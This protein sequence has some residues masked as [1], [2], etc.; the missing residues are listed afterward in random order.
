MEVFVTNDSEFA[1]RLLMNCLRKSGLLSE[2]RARNLSIIRRERRKF[3][4]RKSLKRLRRLE[5]KGGPREGG[6]R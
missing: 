6:E 4:E 2:L 5:K 3:K 1:L